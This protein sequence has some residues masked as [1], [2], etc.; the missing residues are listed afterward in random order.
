[1]IE[2]ADHLAHSCLLATIAKPFPRYH[3]R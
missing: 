1:M 3:C 2:L